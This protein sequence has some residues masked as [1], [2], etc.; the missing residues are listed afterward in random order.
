MK[1]EHQN[2]LLNGR[3]VAIEDILSEKEYPQSPFEQDVLRFCRHW[4]KHQQTFYFKTSGSTGPPKEIAIKRSRIIASINMTSEAL[5]LTK[6]LKALLCIPVSNTGGKMMIAR[7]LQLQMKLECVEP[8]GNPLATAHATPDFIAVVPLQLKRIL[9][10]T[11]KKPLDKIKRIIVGGA[12]V[13]DKLQQD[14]QPVKG[15]IYAT[16]GMTE[17]ASHIALK[18]LNTTDRQQY[19]H[20]LPGIE[21]DNDERDCLK[22]KGPVTD[23]EWIQTND[24]V[25]IISN[26]EFEWLGRTDLV[27]NSGGYK[28]QPEVVERKLQAIFNKIGIT[29]SFFIYG[30]PDNRLGEKCSLFIEGQP[31]DPTVITAI[32]EEIKKA[33]PAF[34]RPKSIRFIKKFTTTASGKLDRRGTVGSML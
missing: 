33:L 1:Y 30:L 20:I 24:R 22:V 5:Q 13:D 8:S 3:Q 23:N 2:I 4:L 19:F 29:N 17:T 15:R 34:E 18:L 32:Q 26:N 16:Y 31:V 28:I 21:I 12:R 27:I 11:G 9:A 6:D 10:D 14:V 7:A 25:R